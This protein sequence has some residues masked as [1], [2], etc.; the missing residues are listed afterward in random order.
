M[1]ITLTRDHLKVMVNGFNK[2]VPR[3]GSL[4]FLHYLLIEQDGATNATITA[5]NMEETLQY[6]VPA[7]VENSDSPQS[8]L[9][10]FD[11]LKKLGLRKGDHV[12]LEP[13]TDTA[14]PTVRLAASIGGQTIHSS[15]ASMAET[16]FPRTL[17]TV[18]V[19]SYP[20]GMLL[21]AYRKAI[22]FASTDISRHVINGV[23]HHAEEHAL[24]GTNGHQLG[25]LTIPDLPDDTDFIL[26][27]SRLLR[28]GV[29]SVGTGAIGVAEHNERQI[30]ELHAGS[31]R[32]QVK[33]VD[34]LYPN[35]RQVIPPEN[36]GFAGRISFAEDDNAL[37]KATVKQFTDDDREFV[38]IYGDTER[39][40]IL[41]ADVQEDG[42]RAH[43]TLP[44]STCSC[45]PPTVQAINGSYL[46]E[47]LK[48]GFN[49]CL[50]PS[51][52][53]PWRCTGSMDGLHV[54]MPWRTE[55]TERQHIADF[56][57]TTTTN[58]DQGEQPVDTPEVT[59]ETNETSTQ[60]QGTAGST[61]PHNPS[62]TLVD[63]DPV[64]ELIDAVTEAV[65][66]V[67]TANSALRGIKGKIKAVEKHYRA[68]D[69]QFAK[70]EKV[71]A[72]LQEVVNF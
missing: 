3:N 52:P 45:D 40:V 5:T 64:A 30:V 13:G 58:Q 42:M 37:I 59:P 48:A 35:Y 24:I 55:A 36:S 4:P 26:P 31:W 43:I 1:R 16:E 10:A 22:T 68:R 39:V 33:C 66:A 62:L 12:V 20:V 6:A 7:S 63:H 65:E 41:N 67:K 11:A 28:N 47:G 70:S 46:L 72:Q 14:L 23:F 25:L 27:P 56:V 2:I 54:V 60:D 38:Y 15:L 9:V 57:A 53:A 69:K 61:T 51:E 71:L 8:F 44:N 18:S 32:Y 29:L 34:G 19:E 49:A 21:D 50:V 17:K